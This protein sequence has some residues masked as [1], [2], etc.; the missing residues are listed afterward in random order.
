[1][2]I[3]RRGRIWGPL[4]VIAHQYPWNARHCLES[5]ERFVSLRRVNL[6]SARYV[7]YCSENCCCCLLSP[8]SCPSFA[9]YSVFCTHSHSHRT[10]TDWLAFPFSQKFFI[11]LDFYN[12]KS[13]HPWVFFFFSPILFAIFMTSNESANVDL[14][15][16]LWHFC[17][18]SSMNL[19]Q[20][21]WSKAFAWMWWWPHIPINGHP[22]VSKSLIKK[23]CS[24]IANERRSAWRKN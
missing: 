10:S 8:S 14:S 17:T 13:L 6:T 7:F 5:G 20:W 12:A 23:N 19:K 21:K 3:V 22:T 16:K 15:R 18:S 9:C 11:N 24:R 4:C 2:W 1:M